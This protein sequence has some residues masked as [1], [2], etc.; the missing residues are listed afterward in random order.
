MAVGAWTPSGTKTTCGC[1]TSEPEPGI[2]LTHGGNNA[3]PVWTADGQRL[4]FS[5]T[6][7]TTPPAGFTGTWWGN[8]YEIR[9]DGSREAERLTTSDESQALTGISADGHELFYTRLV[10]SREYQLVRVDRSHRGET[11]VLTSGPFHHASAELSPDGRLL[12]YRSDESG[13]YEVY[14]QS[15]PGLDAKIAVSVG[16]GLAPVWAA[17][18]DT[19]YHG[20]A[21]ASWPWTSAVADA[22][23]LGPSRAVH[24]APL[25]LGGA[26]GRQYHIGPDGRFLMSRV[27]TLALQSSAGDPFTVVLNWFDE[28][29]AAAR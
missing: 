16:G 21:P 25:P 8:L 9:A 4:I 6:T 2:R 19:L 29:R 15:Y 5:S 18:G 12:A 1:S 13:S 22:S 10:S 17:R 27:P 26:G 7:N 14:V 20:R 24:G 11:T 23:R 28:L 3:L